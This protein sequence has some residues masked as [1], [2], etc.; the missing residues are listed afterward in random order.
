[1]ATKRGAH[2]ALSIERLA[3]L[4]G[5]PLQRIGL[6]ATA[7]PPDEVAHFLGGVVAEVDSTRSSSRARGGRRA[8]AGARDAAVSPTRH[9]HD[10]L[11]ADTSGLTF[12]PITIVDTAEPK[13]LDLRVKRAGRGHGAD[14]TD[15]RSR[16]RAGVAGSQR[17]SI[18]TAIHP[19]LL[20]LHPPASVHAAVRQQPR[21][22]ER[23]AAALNELAGETLVRSHHGSIAREQRTEVEEQLKAGLLQGL[24][25]TS[26]LELGIDMGAIDLVVQIEARPRWRAV[27]NGS[28]ARDTTWARRAGASSSPSIGATCWPARPSRA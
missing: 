23:L 21:V 27:S 8:A 3:A 1:V 26:S 14:R 18:W 24:V 19:R 22:A 5:R 2:L 13:R 25:A 7:R 20:D 16:Q 28:A 9:L 6:S 17:T 12:R 11:A 10:E 4:S 15:R